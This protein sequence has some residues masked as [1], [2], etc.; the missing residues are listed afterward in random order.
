MSD[1]APA[2]YVDG[3]IDEILFYDGV[4]NDSQAE[5]LYNTTQYNSLTVAVYDENSNSLIEYVNLTETHNGVSTDY[6]TDNGVMLLN[7]PDIEEYKFTYYS[8]IEYL[9]RTTYYNVTEGHNLAN[10][11]LVSFLNDGTKTYHVI[12]S[13]ENDLNNVSV[14]IYRTVGGEE[15]MVAKDFTD[16]AGLVNFIVDKSATYTA[17]FEKEGYDT[18]T[19]SL[20]YTGEV[21]TIILGADVAVNSS[22]EEGLEF[23]YSPTGSE[24]NNHTAYNFSHSMNSSFWTI[25]TCNLSLSNSTGLLTSI[26]GTYN[27]TACNATIEY[28]VASSDYITAKLLYELN[29]THT[30]FS[31]AEYVIENLYTANFSLMT[32]IDDIT[33]FDGFGFNAFSRMLV[34]FAFVM[35]VV[36]FVSEKVD[37]LNN[38]EPQ[39]ILALALI[40]LISTTGWFNMTYGN[41]PNI[42]HLRQYFIFIVCLLAGGAYL[43]KEHI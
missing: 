3:I 7:T 38:S 9:T 27:D 17:I 36:A 29:G 40:F 34:G 11:Y 39:I 42:P 18:K 12:D 19:Y 37:Q 30:G 2:N 33:E 23:S 26:I 31:S 13:L 22:E 21:Q 20:V 8:G 4:I 43:A 16:D 14:E 10:L 35:I 28:N 1:F 41:M 25:T 32:V 5:E 24:L 6:T 15:A